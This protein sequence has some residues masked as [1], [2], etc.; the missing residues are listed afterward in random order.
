MN[1]NLSNILKTSLS[2]ES[3]IFAIATFILA[4][5]L[6]SAPTAYAAA[7]DLEN[8][9]G[10]NGQELTT[11]NFNADGN[12]LA[13]QSDGK[14]VVAGGSQVFDESTVNCKS[15]NSDNQSQPSTQRRSWRPCC[16]PNQR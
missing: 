13:V 4:I 11:F 15:S 9:F 3:F 10:T 7:G 16:Y 2:V 8:N 14:I 5:S 1:T 6:S 12:A